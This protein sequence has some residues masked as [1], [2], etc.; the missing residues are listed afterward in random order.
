M[1]V[2]N[3]KLWVNKSN[4]RTYRSQSGI[5]LLGDWFL[6]RYWGS[7]NVGVGNSRTDIFQTRELLVSAVRALD[8]ERPKRG[9][10]LI[11]STNNDY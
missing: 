7:T 1:A 4:Q 9:Y 3:E 5:D 8:E 10:A 6:T 2:I 11:E